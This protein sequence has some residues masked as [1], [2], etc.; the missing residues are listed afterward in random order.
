LIANAFKQTLA[1]F[2]VLEC[3]SHERQEKWSGGEVEY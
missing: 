3:W 1:G 2:E